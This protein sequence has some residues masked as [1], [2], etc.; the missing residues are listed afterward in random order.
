M[1]ESSGRF[2]EELIFS[3]TG[4]IYHDTGLFDECISVRPNN[5]AFQGQYCTVFFGLNGISPKEVVERYQNV[6]SLASDE[7]R[8]SKEGEPN[9]NVSAFQMPSISFCLPSTCNAS[10]L[11]WAI[12]QRIGYRFIDDKNVSLV[13]ITNDE[14]CYTQEGINMSRK[15]DN[16]TIVVL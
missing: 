11:R 7:I 8:H 13:A 1:Y 3:G 10:Q 6:S 14:Y 2:E 12:A 9:E 5:V 4:N 15:L 16:L